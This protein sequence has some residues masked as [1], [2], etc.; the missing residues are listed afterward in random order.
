MPR[1]ALCAVPAPCWLASPL[2]CRI[3]L[4]TAVSSRGHSSCRDLRRWHPVRVLFSSKST[5]DHHARPNCAGDDATRDK[6]CPCQESGIQQITREDNE[7]GHIF[8]PFCA[9]EAR[10]LEL[11]Y[12]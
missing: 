10:Q 12:F 9:L 11:N 4:G 7:S 3:F 8:V 1:G 2:T 6:R 5:T